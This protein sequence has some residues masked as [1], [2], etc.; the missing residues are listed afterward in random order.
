M[1]DDQTMETFLRQP[2][3]FAN[4]PLPAKLPPA[5]LVQDVASLPMLGYVLMSYITA[6]SGIIKYIPSQV[7]H[8][9]RCVIYCL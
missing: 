8:Y 6:N 9:R 4:I 5:K 3:K 2:W 7:I 1:T